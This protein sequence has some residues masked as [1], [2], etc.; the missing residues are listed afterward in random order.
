MTLPLQS[1]TRLTCGARRSAE[2]NRH[3]FPASLRP[4]TWRFS[5][6]SIMAQTIT[7]QLSFT[8]R[9]LF[10]AMLPSFAS[11]S[12]ARVEKEYLNNAV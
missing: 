5:P 2:N 4:K 3:A 11:A 10:A 12:N 9:S 7:F 1:S 6:L 8:L